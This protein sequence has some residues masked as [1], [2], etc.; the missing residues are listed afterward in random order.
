M[1]TKLLQKKAPAPVPVTRPVVERQLNWAVEGGPF[2]HKDPLAQVTESFQQTFDRIG[3]RRAAQ[4]AAAE[5]GREEETRLQAGENGPD[6]ES[7]PG[8]A[9]VPLQVFAEMAFQRGRLASAVLQGTGRMMLATCLQHSI[10]QGEPARSRQ[11]LF[12]AGS[13]VRVVPGSAPDQMVFHRGF[14]RSAV[15]LVVDVLSDARSVVDTLAEMAGGTGALGENEGAWTLR[16]VYPFLDD[17]REQG[18]LEQYRARLA[19]TADV[20]ERQVLQNAV[21]HTGALIARKAQMKN[22]FVNKLRLLSDKAGEALEELQ[23]QDT[24]DYL[25]AALETAA[26]FTPPEPPEEPPGG[27]GDGSSRNRSGRAASR[28]EASPDAA[29]QPDRDGRPQGTE[30]NQTAKPKAGTEPQ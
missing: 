17:S 14:A 19:G 21:V 25:T 1:Q 16:R 10:G 15:G 29:E 28:K 5:G 9:Q 7:R 8:P 18:L 30:P 3:Q 13:Q 6:A 2:Q 22:E 12:G 27:E 11:V 26:S 4:L 20:Q 24:L 23:D